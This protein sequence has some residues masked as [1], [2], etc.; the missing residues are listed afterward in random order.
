M[1]LIEPQSNKK[2]PQRDAFSLVLL[3]KWLK[4]CCGSPEFLPCPNLIHIKG[5]HTAHPWPHYS[6]KMTINTPKVTN[7][8]IFSWLQRHPRKKLTFEGSENKKN[9][10]AGILPKGPKW[11]LEKRS[12]GC[13]G[14]FLAREIWRNFKCPKMMFFSSSV[15]QFLD[16]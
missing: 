3:W 12:T 9:T 5:D 6:L 1:T 2:L 14:W 11:I 13:R 10:I 15:F 8:F 16:N 4:S 7:F